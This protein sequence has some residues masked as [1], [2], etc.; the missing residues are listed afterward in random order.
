M[1]IQLY[2]Y[3]CVSTACVDSR[4]LKKNSAFFFGG[5]EKPI[6]VHIARAAPLRDVQHKKKIHALYQK[7]GVK[8]EFQCISVCTTKRGYCRDFHFF[9]F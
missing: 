5:G 1:S 6:S 7:V 8:S 4:K 9:V 3:V 2:I